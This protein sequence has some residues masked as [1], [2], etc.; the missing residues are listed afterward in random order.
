MADY[1]DD[2]LE[3]TDWSTL[4]QSRPVLTPMFGIKPLTPFGRC[5]HHGPL[6]KGSPF[7]CMY[8]HK[9]GKD[10][11]VYFRAVKAKK[12]EPVQGPASKPT[13]YLPSKKTAAAAKATRKDRRA[14][15]RKAS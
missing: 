1:E 4:G 2:E 13:K 7:V 12:P 15:Q 10:H 8:C 9:S 3:G 6:P 5:P 11:Y 14:S